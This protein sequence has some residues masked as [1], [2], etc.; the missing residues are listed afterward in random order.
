MLYFVYE[1]VIYPHAAA[2]CMAHVAADCMGLTSAGLI[3]GKGN[4]VIINIKHG[5]TNCQPLFYLVFNIEDI[6]SGNVS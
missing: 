1:I 3:N 6:F 5:T 4:M 2:G